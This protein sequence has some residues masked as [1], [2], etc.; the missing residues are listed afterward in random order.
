MSDGPPPDLPRPRYGFNRVAG[1]RTATSD[2][3][4]LQLGTDTAADAAPSESVL[5]GDIEADSVDKSD[6]PEE[7][8]DIEDVLATVYPH[9]SQ[10]FLYVDPS[11]PE[12]MSIFQ[13]FALA[14]EMMHGRRHRF[15]LTRSH[16]LTT[17][18]YLETFF[19]YLQGD[20]PVDRAAEQIVTYRT[21]AHRIHVARH[22]LLETVDS[23]LCQSV[24]SESG[25]LDQHVDDYLEANPDLDRET[26]KQRF[27]R[28]RD[29]FRQA[30]RSEDE[31]LYERLDDLETRYDRRIAETVAD[32]V[33]DIPYL[34]EPLTESGYDSIP[35]SELDFGT[36]FDRAVAALDELSVSDSDGVDTNELR[37]DLEA[38][39]DEQSGRPKEGRHPRELEM[40]LLDIPQRV[41]PNETGEQRY[42]AIMEAPTS[43]GR[44]INAAFSF[45]G[46]FGGVIYRVPGEDGS[47]Y[48]NWFVNPFIYDEPVGPTAGRPPLGGAETYQ[49]LWERVYVGERLLNSL[50]ENMFTTPKR[51]QCP[52]CAISMDGECADSGCAY[53]DVVNAANQRRHELVDALENAE[54][55]ALGQ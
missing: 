36:R 33:L 46:N 28:V 14:E 49:E 35:P 19:D 53:A 55:S 2:Q 47:L 12:H 44:V 43:L 54:R 6:L 22:S 7:F 30:A 27:E 4:P 52:L 13:A 51:V 1:K 34:I 42:D 3:K 29:T 18:R 23:Y 15:G 38:R 39:I 41:A 11:R 31:A 50:G 8:R 5:F 10:F 25:Y 16:H 24:M 9:L 17:Y 20:R 26:A 40:P 37:R 21:L 48:N 32:T 45:Q